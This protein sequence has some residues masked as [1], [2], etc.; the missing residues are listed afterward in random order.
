VTG[1]ADENFW[2]DI[3]R[4]ISLQR[5]SFAASENYIQSTTPSLIV[6]ETLNPERSNEAQAL[7]PE[8]R[9]EAVTRAHSHQPKRVFD[10][11]H[12][13]CMTR[14]R[15]A[16]ADDTCKSCGPFRTACPYCAT[17]GHAFRIHRDT[18]DLASSGSM[19]CN[20][21]A[22]RQPTPPPHHNY[23]CFYFLFSPIYTTYQTRHF[24]ML[25]ASHYFIFKLPSPRIS[26]PSVSFSFP[27]FILSL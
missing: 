25:S 10:H 14:E 6:V 17:F 1:A 5:L 15:R 4:A 24:I 21:G 8:G 9:L 22:T 11:H 12:K 23:Y 26:I 27:C 19:K 2:S 18:N 3:A 13:R 16:V 7:I 20:S